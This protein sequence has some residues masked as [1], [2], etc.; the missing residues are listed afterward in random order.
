MTNPKLETIVSHDGN[1]FDDPN[2]KIR[3]QYDTKT[4]DLYVNDKRV[5]TEIDFKKSE[6]FLA[7]FVAGSVAIQAIM[8]VAS[9]FEC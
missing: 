4:N 6:K 2:A 1:S 8:S 5:V 9:Y 3:L 7:W